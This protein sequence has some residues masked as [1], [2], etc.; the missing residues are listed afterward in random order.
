MEPTQ[1]ERPPD[2]DEVTDAS[3]LNG[4]IEEWMDLDNPDEAPTTFPEALESYLTHNVEL[5]R[6]GDTEPE[7]RQRLAR[8]VTTIQGWLEKFRAMYENLGQEKLCRTTRTR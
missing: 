7:L 2:T 5:V 4:I 1:V 6:D 3:V 8:E